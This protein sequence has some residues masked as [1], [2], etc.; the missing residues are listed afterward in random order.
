MEALVK[1]KVLPLF[2]DPDWLRSYLDGQGRN[3]GGEY[4]ERLTRLGKEINRW[5]T[6]LHN[7]KRQ[8]AWG[9]WTDEE[10]QHERDKAR[11][12]LGRSTDTADLTGNDIARGIIPD[13]IDRT[14]LEKKVIEIKKQYPPK[15]SAL[16]V[17]GV[18]AYKLA[19]NKKEF[20]LKQRSIKIHEFNIL[21][22]D[23]PFLTYRTTVSKGTYI[24][25]LTE[26]IAELLNTV[27]TTVQ[28]KRTSVG[29]IRLEDSVNLADLNKTNWPD[30]L[31]PLPDIFKDKHRLILGSEECEDFYHGRKIT[32]QN[33]DDNDLIILDEQGNCLG[34]GE[35]MG[36]QLHPRVVFK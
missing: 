28:L 15:F 32:V 4:K 21:D 24:R 17:K 8:H 6:Y 13:E 3:D 27:G 34:F 19:R 16:K 35:V 20:S 36:S 26:Q 12:E 11:A 23:P 25:S 22:Y 31:I 7:L 29:A 14:S 10:Y 5:L 9:D 33:K 1:T 2:T 30:H 18:P